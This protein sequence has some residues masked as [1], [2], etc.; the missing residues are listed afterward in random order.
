MSTFDGYV[1]LGLSVDGFI[2]RL[3]GDLDWLVSRG[4]A[5]GD[6]GFTDFLATV[7]ALLM[8][9]GTYEAI[10][11]F[12]EWPYGKTPVHLLSSTFAGEDRRLAGVHRTLDDSIAALTAAGHRRVYVDG[13]ATVRAFLA[14]GLIRELTLSSVPVLIGSGFTLFGSLPHDVELEHLGTRVIGGSMV[15]T[16]YRVLPG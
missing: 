1:F 2:A 5:A 10:V 6:I 14:R 16:H 11:D 12:P 9:R 8:G 3:D 15:Q 4:E 13:G 7:D